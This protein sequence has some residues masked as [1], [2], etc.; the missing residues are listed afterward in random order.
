MY[1]VGL[2]RCSY[3]GG[4]TCKQSVFRCQLPTT[5]GYEAGTEHGTEARI[6]VL[7]HFFGKAGGGACHF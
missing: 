2:M 7:L 6:R 1:T 3:L 5:V 4:S